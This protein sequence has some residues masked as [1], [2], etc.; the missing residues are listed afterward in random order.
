MP[1]TN[2]HGPKRAILY[3]RVSTD[4]QARTGFSLAQQLEALREYAAR[5]GYDVLEEVQDAGQSGASLERPGMDRVRDL[6]AADG[7]SVVLAQ[8]RD[9]FARE[10]AYHYLL[11]EEFALRGCVLRSL[12]D[13]GDDSPEGQLADGIMDQI[14]RFERLKTAERTRR[15]KLQRAREGKIVPTRYVTYGFALN[16]DR[17]NYVVDEEKMRVVRCVVSMAA[18]GTPIHGIKRAL[19]TEGV[20]TPSGG[21]YWH[22]GAIEA[23]IT[24]D[25]YRPHTFDEISELVTPQVAARLDPDELY[26]V[27]WYN[28]KR[29]KRSQNSEPGPQGRVYRR[30]R[31]Y[32]PKVRS[33]WIAVPVPDAGIPLD[34]LEAARSTVR[35]YKTGS[36]ASG[37]VWELSGAVARCALCG[38]WISPR[39][40]KYKLKDGSE[41]TINYYRCSKAYGYSGRCEHT[42]T[43]RAEDLEERVWDLVLSLL[44]EPERLRPALD[45]LIEEERKAHRGDPEREARVWLKK[46]T[47]V[48]RMRGRFQDMAAEGLITFGELRA[49]LESLEETRQVARREL[50][51]LEERRTR[52]AD[53]ERD[54][55]A[56]LE[57][58]SEKASKGLDHFTPEVRHDTYKKLQL[59]VLVHPGGDLEVTGL[60]GLSKISGHPRNTGRRKRRRTSTGYRRSAAGGVA[61]LTRVAIGGVRYGCP[62][63]GPASVLI[64]SGP[65]FRSPPYS[66]KRS[67]PTSGP[68][69]SPLFTRVLGR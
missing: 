52:L 36:R 67:Q 30:R 27:W 20:P 37:R 35:D 22:C 51:A 46:I 15:G 7:V 25:V 48:D 42:K 13:R 2:D 5:E 43:Y 17:T 19:D 32:E 28:R 69:F 45:R 29:V 53:L 8:D 58:Y 23:F 18:E 3:A 24:D 63:G 14:A 64:S 39:P 34:V 62:Q 10:P 57:T 56:L 4:E 68:F 47:E 40:V 54:N 66:G 12:N 44:R 61:V 16:D 60:L 6:V 21:P 9:R 41:K 38:R 59:A 31:K 49:K 33:E 1:G 11:R 65:R 55:D 26:G 50:A